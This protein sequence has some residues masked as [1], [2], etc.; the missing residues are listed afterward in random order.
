VAQDAL[1]ALQTRPSPGTQ[2][3]ANRYAPRVGKGA[4]SVNNDV[5]LIHNP[6][7]LLREEFDEWAILFDLLPIAQAL[8]WELC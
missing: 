1:I 2:M 7:A 4:V 8:I 3:S 6:Y 5:K